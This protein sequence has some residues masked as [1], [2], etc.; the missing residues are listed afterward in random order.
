M[1]FWYCKP[2]FH[3][4]LHKSD[5]ALFIHAIGQIGY[6]ECPMRSHM[7]QGRQHEGRE[8]DDGTTSSLNMSPFEFVA[9]QKLLNT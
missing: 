9:D 7:V 6:D 5:L 2:F 4:P 1:C 8:F 3:Q